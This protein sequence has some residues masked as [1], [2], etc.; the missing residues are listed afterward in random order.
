M[1]LSLLTFL[2]LLGLVAFF[3][4]RRIRKRATKREFYVYLTLI[5]TATLVGALFILGYRLPSPMEPI[6]KLFSPIGR[7]LTGGR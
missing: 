2:L 4:G 6:D 1:F 5:G 3:D 7:W